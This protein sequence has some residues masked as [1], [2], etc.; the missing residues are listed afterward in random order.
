MSS[1]SEAMSRRS[2]IKAIAVLSVCPLIQSCEFVNHD[3]LESE[4][5]ATGFSLDDPDFEDLTSVGGTACFA[6][7]AVEVLLVRTS[8]QEVLAFNRI[9]PHNSLSMGPCDS[10]AQA[11]QWDEQ[12]E[13]LVCQWHQSGFDRNGE[14]VQQPTVGSVDEPLQVYP[15]EFDAETGEGIVF[16][17]E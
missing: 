17:P 5:E 6:L 8:E 13:M 11:A 9:C 4:L 16:L 7:G 1:D 3:G 12:E 14:V 15:V 2:A 10:G